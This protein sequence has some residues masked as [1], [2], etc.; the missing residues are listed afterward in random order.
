MRH[1][2]YLIFIIIS[3]FSAPAF[4]DYYVYYINNGTINTG[5]QTS[6]EAACNK[7]VSMLGTP[8]S[9]VRVSGIYCVFDNMNGSNVVSTGQIGIT[10]K[11]VS[12]PPI[13]CPNSGSPVPTYFEPNTPIPVRVC[14]QNAD[15]TYCIYDAPDKNNPIVIS[16][17]N[18]QSITLSSVS[19][20]PSPSCTPQFSKTSCD[21]KDPYGGCYQPPDDNCNRMAD[22]S[23]YC[24]EG[25]PP[26][27]IQSG[28]SNN[29]T[30]CDMP[31]TGCGSNYV[32]GTFNGKQ[33]CVRNSN[34][35]PIDPI[36]QPPSASEPP[37]IDPNDPPPASSPPPAIPPESSTIL[38]SIL[39]AINAVNNKLTWVK[40]EIVNSVNNVSRT[41]GITNQK[42]DAVNS[43]VKETTAAVKETTAAV[44]NVKA[45][46]DANATTVKTAVEAN[47]AA[48]NG[49]KSAVEAN[50]SST[51]NKL[52]EVVNA[53]NNKPVGGGGGT[54]VNLEPTNNLLKGIQDWL[55]VSD[56]TNP[57]DGEIKVVK[58][59]I[60]T[61]FDGNLVNATGTCPQPMQISF[62]I[63]QT[64]T[65]QFSYETFCLGASLARPW[66]IFVGMLT[67]FFIV[68]GHYRGGSND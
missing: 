57:E 25:T 49:V 52:N 33:I 17:G 27:P 44:N 42:L 32:P 65:I 30:Y 39:D 54:A 22:G 26:P 1:L 23:I 19:A 53:I 37:P 48:T 14:K 43:S 21:P 28:C 55:A 10:K 47:T 66:I 3:L 18:Y 63:V 50:T 24:P 31:P 58:N 7:Y 9:N 56:D 38:R 4:A 13:T 61:N 16:T 41:L 45:A 35:P 15:G 40:D 51:A 11:L 34:P 29:A 6:Y 2:K 12:A 36:P 62:S 67:A 60:D 20:V 46:V 5:Y 59:E 8:T 68:T 64:Y